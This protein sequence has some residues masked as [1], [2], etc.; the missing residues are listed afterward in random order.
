MLIPR[1]MQPP[2]DRVDPDVY[3]FCR[4]MPGHPRAPGRLTRTSAGSVAGAGFARLCLHRCPAV[5]PYQ[6]LA[7]ELRDAG[8]AARAADIIDGYVRG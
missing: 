1:I 6:A 4:A 3:T 2:A 5:F 7:R 8:R